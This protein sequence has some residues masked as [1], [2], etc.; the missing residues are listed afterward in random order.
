MR[1]A[2]LEFADVPGLR[3]VEPLGYFDFLALESTARLVLTDSGGV[4]EETTAF[5]YPA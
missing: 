5:V 1:E 2:G 4:Q 3:V